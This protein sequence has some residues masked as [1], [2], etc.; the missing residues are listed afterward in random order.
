MTTLRQL[1]NMAVRGTLTPLILEGCILQCLGS[2]SE[3]V[4]NGQFSLDEKNA[5]VPCWG[6]RQITFLLSTQFAI[7][8]RR[9]RISPI[10]RM[11]PKV[12]GAKMAKLLLLNEQKQYVHECRMTKSPPSFL[13]IPASVSWRSAMKPD[14]KLASFI[15][16]IGSFTG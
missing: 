1:T 12:F 4:K 3:S 7:A 5:Q 11:F 9:I 8:A 6:N 16:I 15:K 14:T 10:T 13:A 2:I